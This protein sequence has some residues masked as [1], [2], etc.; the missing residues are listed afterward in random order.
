[1]PT[2]PDLLRSSLEQHNNT[3]ESLL[4]LIPAKYY[5]VED[6]TE[7]QA[8]SKYQ[9]HSKK[10][11]A[12]KQAIKEMSKKAKREKLDPKNNKTIL[13]IQNEAAQRQAVA[14]GKRRA[15]SGEDS[16]GND[17]ADAMDVDADNV[18]LG[19]ETSTG[20]DMSFVPMPEAGGIETLRQKL[21]SRMEQLRK[22]KRGEGDQATSK[23]E[24]IEERRKQRA[25]MRE[26]RRKE[27]KEKIRLEKEKKEK[28]GKDKSRDKGNQS[29]PTSL[30]VEQPSTSKAGPSRDPK[31]TL[32]NVAFSAI[33]GS[34][35]ISNKK[36]QHV[37]TTSDPKQ[38]LQQLE[39][40]KEKLAALPEEKRKAIEE[41]SKWEKAEARIE[42]VKVKDDETRLKKAAKRKEKEKAKS[43]K[44][45]DERKKEVRDQMA[46]RQ[47]KRADNIAMRAERRKGGSSGKS[48]ARPGFEGKSFGKSKKAAG[49]RKK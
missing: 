6:E 39:T 19:M 27:T 45:W 9:K 42:G 44:A 17:D 34:P 28:P 20:E 21:H 48:K 4:K 11:K 41:K 29:K 35:G 36:L 5:I 25:M 30:L 47:K 8:A 38:A 26:R 3:F 7:E 15:D 12:P 2:P 33:A 23:D 32:T 40:R 43:K 46:A 22:G 13:D 18:I 1:M 49:N 37:K 10:T 24:L 14:K 16:D 31:D